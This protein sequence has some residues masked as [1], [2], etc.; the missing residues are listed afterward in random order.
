MLKELGR[1]FKAFPLSFGVPSGLPSTWGVRQW[2]QALRSGLVVGDVTIEGLMRTSACISCCNLLADTIASAPI[3]VKQR[4]PVKGLTNVT[5]STASD[6]LLNFN[7]DHRSA[8][9]WGC[10]LLGNGWILN[11][12]QELT[13]LDSFSTTVFIDPNGQV[14]LKQI[15]GAFIPFES[16]A[17]LKFRHQSPFLLGFNPAILAQDSLKSALGL[18]RMSA[19]LAEHSSVPGE[20]IEVDNALSDKA[21]SNIKKSWGEFP[22]DKSVK[23]LEEG[24]KLKQLEPPSATDAQMIGALEWSVSDIAR[25]YGIPNSLVNVAV[26]G[27]NKA[28]ASED[29]RSFYQR[30]V[31]PWAARLTD[32]L[33]RQL[34]T[35]EERRAGLVVALDLSSLTIGY[36][37]EAGEYWAQLCNSGIAST[38][39]ARE[40]IDLPDV[41]EGS[42]VRVPSNMIFLDKLDQMP[43]GAANNAPPTPAR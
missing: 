6:L 24:A 8:A 17:H 1:W 25:M 2:A 11:D 37:K 40:G 4:D 26:G 42:R 7:F 18:I 41:P 14:W 34:F 3:S 12:G 23:V 27:A 38:D 21:I 33:G 30:A 28:T 9:I 19:A 35:Q 39:D 31:R 36:G 29:V 10:A 16:V 13:S 22:D 32:S 20:I 5:Q 15:T 43:V